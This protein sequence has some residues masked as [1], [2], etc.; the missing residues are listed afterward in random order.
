MPV[1][2]FRSVEEMNAPL[3][4]QPREPELYQTVVALGAGERMNTDGCRSA[5]SPSTTR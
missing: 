4:R 3:W 2:R 1:R 5:R